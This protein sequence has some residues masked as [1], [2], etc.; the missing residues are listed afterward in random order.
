MGWWLSAKPG[1][2]VVCVDP[3]FHAPDE[4]FLTRGVT[5]PKKGAVYTIR[6][7]GPTWSNASV[8][9]LL[10]C[11]LVN[12]LIRVDEMRFEVCWPVKNFRPVVSRKTDISIFTAML[13]GQPAKA[14]A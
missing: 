10:L 8:Y 13:T 3:Q 6:L 7:I 12:P 11:E 2:R 14:D 4:W 9:V 5:L 1:D